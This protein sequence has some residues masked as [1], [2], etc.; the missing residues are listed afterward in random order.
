[1]SGSLESK[2]EFRILRQPRGGNH[3]TGRYALRAGTHTAA[4][5]SDHG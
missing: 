1:M 5:G 4:I 2:S 3:P